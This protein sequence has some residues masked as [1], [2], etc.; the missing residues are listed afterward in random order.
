MIIACVK[1]GTYLL[2]DGSQVVAKI[3]RLYKP[4]P[5]GPA[6]YW[7]DGY[8]LKWPHDGEEELF[9]TLGDIHLQYECENYPGYN[10]ILKGQ[11][12]S[13]K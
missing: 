12:G 11:K 4:A 7:H 10:A 8:S 1:S 9:R 13:Y 5:K 3:S 6:K 2:I